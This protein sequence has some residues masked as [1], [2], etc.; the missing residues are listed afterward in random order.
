M[1]DA[2]AS[3]CSSTNTSP[4]CA[5]VCEGMKRLKKRDT[6]RSAPCR[7]AKEPQPDTLRRLMPV[8]SE[9]A[10]SSLSPFKESK[11]AWA[12]RPPSLG[13]WSILAMAIFLDSSTQ[14]RQNPYSNCFRLK[15]QVGT[16]KTRQQ[17]TFTQGAAMQPGSQIPLIENA[18]CT[19]ALQ[20]ACLY[21]CSLVT[22][23]LCKSH[24]CIQLLLLQ[25]TRKH[26]IAQ[27]SE[28]KHQ[29]KGHMST[30]AVDIDS[31]PT[32]AAHSACC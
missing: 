23:L 3:L 6:L 10:S 14:H 2:K 16:E 5:V 4:V 1:C 7:L 17:M 12:P 11:L 9:K 25:V 24:V 27:R 32:H 28:E 15:N 21:W 8:T 26:S 18:T 13:A 20:H 29:G 22:D 30:T 19:T 31:I